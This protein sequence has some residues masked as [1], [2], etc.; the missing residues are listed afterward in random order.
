M[1]TTFKGTPLTNMYN[2]KVTINGRT[3]D[4]AEAA[5]QSFKT[6]SKLSRNRFVGIDGY[7]AKRLGRELPLRGDWETVKVQIMKK[8][9]RAKFTQSKV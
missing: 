5:F 3:F 6:T 4:N 2:A 7:S 9:L 8:V 1:L